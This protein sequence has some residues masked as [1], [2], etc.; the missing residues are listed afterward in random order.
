MEC[1][2]DDMAVHNVGGPGRRANAPLAQLVESIR[3]ISERSPVQ[4]RQGARFTPRGAYSIRKSVT[5]ATQVSVRE[6][7]RPFFRFLKTTIYMIKRNQAWF[8]KV[9]RAIKSIIIFSLRMI[10]ATVLGL[11]SIVS[12]FEWYEKPLNIH[13]LILAIISIFIVVHQ[14]VIMTY[15]SEK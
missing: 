11:M 10:A 12:I 9:F 14:I 5:I 8:W 1:D 3:L 2:G 15:E 13:L 7:M 4:A 6:D